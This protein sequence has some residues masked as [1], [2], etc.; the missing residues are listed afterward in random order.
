[1]K[2]EEFDP[3]KVIGSRGTTADTHSRRS[4]CCRHCS[5]P[6]FPCSSAIRTAISTR[7][8]STLRACSCI[9]RKLTMPPAARPARIWAHGVEG[10]V[11]PPP[12]ALDLALQ[13]PQFLKSV[14]QVGLSI[15]WPAP[16][17]CSGYVLSLLHPSDAACKRL[18]MPRTPLQVPGFVGGDHPVFA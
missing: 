3:S 16:N 13:R 12:L 11:Q 18:R 17:E 14:R 15:S 10:P 8:R 4:A 2:V 6:Q 7:R 5:V 1:M 9:C